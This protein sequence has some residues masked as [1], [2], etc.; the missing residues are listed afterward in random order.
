[1]IV[2]SHCI[3]DISLSVFMV[4]C[5]ISNRPCN[6]EVNVMSRYVHPRSLQYNFFDSSYVIVSVF[7]IVRSFYR[8]NAETSQVRPNLGDKT[9]WEWAGATRDQNR[10]WFQGVSKQ[11]R[12]GVYATYERSL[13]N[14]PSRPSDWTV[15]SSCVGAYNTPNFLFYCGIMSVRSQG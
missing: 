10:P 15:F 8:I 14:P 12:D 4:G 2:P 6:C 13:Q 3:M 1:M 9:P 5:C 11:E 7:L